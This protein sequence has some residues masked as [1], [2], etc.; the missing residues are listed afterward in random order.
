MAFSSSIGILLGILPLMGIS[1]PLVL[2]LNF[3]VPLNFPALL[4]GVSLPFVLSILH[5]ISF[6]VGQKLLGFQLPYEPP[7]DLSFIE[8][9]QWTQGNQVHLLGSL[10][11]GI[12]FAVIF[13]PVFR[14]IYL[15]PIL[16]NDHPRKEFI[17]L[18]HSGKRW[19]FATRILAII[20]TMGI[21]IG[22]IFG[23]SVGIN[24]VLPGFPLNGVNQFSG[25]QPI[26]QELGGEALTKHV[27][28]ESGNQSLPGINGKSKTLQNVYAF[29]VSWDEKSKPHLEKNIDSIQVLVPDWFSLNGQLNVYHKIDSQVDAM[30]QSKKVKE[31]PLISNY[32]NNKWDEE[33]LHQLLLNQKAQESIIQDLMKQC[34]EHHYLGINLDFEGIRDEDKELYLA[35]VT[36]M[37]RDFHKQGLQL[38]VDVPPNR[39][40]SIDYQALSG[41]VNQVILKMFDEHALGG[42]PGPVASGKFVQ[43]SLATLPVPKEKLVVALDNYGYDWVI[44]STTYQQISFSDVMNMVAEKNLKIYWNKESGNPYVRYRKGNEEHIIWFQDGS[45]YYNQL[46]MTLNSGVSGV[47]LW[48]LGAEDPSIWK[49]LK[50]SRKLPN[51]SKGLEVVDHPDPVQFIGKGEILKIVSQPKQGKRILTLDGNGYVNKEEYDSL[52]TPYK[53]ERYGN[54]QGKQVV[55]TFDDGPDS[56][57]TPKILDILAKYHV[58]ATFFVVGENVE[59]APALIQRMYQEGHEIGNHTYTHPNLSATS[60]LQTKLELNATQRMIQ[61]VTGH[62]SLLFRVPYSGDVWPSTSAELT[63]ILRAQTSGYTTIGDLIDPLDWTRPSA[64]TIVKRVNEQLKSGNIILLHDGG[65][66]RRSTLEALPRV[67]ESL[68]SQGYTFVTV[69]QL[70]HTSKDSLMPPV[71][72]MDK[73]YLIYDKLV[74]AFQNGISYFMTYLFYT[75]IVLGVSRVTFLGNYAF[76]QKRKKLWLYQ[77]KD[78]QPRVSVV[79]AAYNEEKVIAHTLR[80]I[81]QSDYP[82]FEIIVVDDGSKDRTVQVIQEQFG[83]DSRIH[84]IQKKNGGK[85]AAINRAIKEAIGEII[86]ALDADTLIKKDAISLFV[87]HFAKQKVAAVSGN[88]KVG[89]VHNLLTTWQHVEYVTGFNLEKRAFSMFNCISVVPGAIGA[90]RKEAVMQCGLFTDETLAEDTDLTL[91]LLKEG[92]KV[93]FEEQAYAYTEAPSDLQAL[94]KQ[95]SRWTFGTLQCLWKYRKQIFHPGH[96]SLGFLALP[97]MWLFQFVFQ[98]LSPLADIYFIFGLFSGAG[99]VMMFYLIFFLVDFLT[100]LYAFKLEGEKPKPLLWIFLQRIIYRQIMA[101]VIIK[102]LFAAVKG[103]A[104]GWNKLNRHGNVEVPSSP[105]HNAKVS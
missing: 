80:S 75:V 46:K 66:D 29:Y 23:I 68:K 97:N 91:Q 84:L 26:T 33:L 17:F 101:Y 90:W 4:V 52:P 14:W 34:K 53:I 2:A 45:T 47:G 28:K 95:R 64:D 49:V 19:G 87:P 69:N 63:P 102:T 8:F 10:I 31:M 13:Y 12:L 60:V 25:V 81:L 93:E 1:I 48:N 11:V 22:V 39:P 76:R 70:L 38:S 61:T 36:K 57:Y 67:I 44:N 94:I 24:P 30:T 71:S 6:L 55:L 103:M 16:H 20:L 51:P 78:Y 73:W 82:D 88:I 59:K 41:V 99:K 56:N 72:S 105:V 62:S 42:D 86:V 35:F 74:F 54:A 85:S 104:V 5:E 21:T 7:E 27:Q 15:L 89:N 92:Y 50:D 37:A 32:T 77:L 18:D 96:K 83:M 79:I 3:I 43:E 9:S 100:A 58:Q 40:G 98:A 65:G